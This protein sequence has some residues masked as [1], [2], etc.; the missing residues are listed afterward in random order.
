LAEGDRKANRTK[1][2]RIERWVRIG[3][4]YKGPKKNVRVL[5]TVRTALVVGQIAFKLGQGTA[6]MAEG[7]LHVKRIDLK[8]YGLIIGGRREKP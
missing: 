1:T 2:C 3:A 8:E 7:H 5:K 4:V 6:C